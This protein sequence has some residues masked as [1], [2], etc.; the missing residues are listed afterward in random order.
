MDN[1]SDP[2]PTPCL[3]AGFSVRQLNFELHVHLQVDAEVLVLFG[4]SGSGKTTTLNAIAGLIVPERG[5]ITLGGQILFQREAGTPTVNLPAHARRLGY[6][7][8]H[9]ALFPHLTA[10]ENV[11]YPLQGREGRKRAAELLDRMGIPHL[12]DRYP[13][14]LSGG[15]NSASQLPAPWRQHL[16]F[17]SWTSPFRPLMSPHAIASSWTLSRCSANC[18]CLSCT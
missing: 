12:A 5:R 7:F 16:V 13:E 17:S 8:Q 1:V 11:A 9:Y 4:P 14:R 18:V 10:L 2:C 3:Y 6:V 15:S